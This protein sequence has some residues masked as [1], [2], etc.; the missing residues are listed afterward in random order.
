[1]SQTQNQ[2]SLAR[3]RQMD[4]SAI[5]HARERAESDPS[6]YWRQIF[7]WVADRIT[8]EMDRCDAIDPIKSA[9]ASQRKLFA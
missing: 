5:A 9:Q 3:S 1:M 6:P 2:E 8:D 7:A 4:E